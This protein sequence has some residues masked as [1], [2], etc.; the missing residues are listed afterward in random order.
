[1]SQAV[2]LTLMATGVAVPALPARATRSTP[3]DFGPVLISDRDIREQPRLRAVGPLFESRELETG[4]LFR[5]L[6]PLFSKVED[7][8]L[9][10]L[11]AHFLWPVGTYLRKGKRSYWRFLSVIGQNRDVEDPASPYRVWVLPVFFVGRDPAG[12]NYLAVFPIGGKINR[13]LG[14]DKVVFV[15]FPLYM[16]SCAGTTRSYD[17]LWPIISRTKGETLSHFRIFPFY[18]KAVRAGR[19]EKM[20]VLWPFWTSAKYFYEGSSGGGFVLFPLFGHVKLEDQESWMV[21]PPFFRWSR[22]KKQNVTYCP[23]PF[24][25]KSSGTIDKLYF[26]PVWGRKAKGNIRQN[27]LFWPVF[28]KEIRETPR[29]VSKSY[30]ARPFVYYQSRTDKEPAAAEPRTKYLKIW[31]LL[32]YEKKESGRRLRLLDLYPLKNNPGIE[33]NW[34]PLW[35][36]YSYEGNAREKEYELL[37]GLFRRRT[38][39]QQEVYTSLFPLVAWRATAD[40]SARE[41]SVLKGLVGYSRDGDRKRFRLLYFL[42][43]GDTDEDDAGESGADEAGAREE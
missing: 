14:R 40:G 12:E 4:E 42:K 5:A 25:Q 30:A 17:V 26:W 7:D 21:L 22:G 34:A 11:Q 20:F 41:W 1:M 43:F 23:W 35:T 31:P 28:S 3:A 33:R 37:W 19:S 15:L 39:P 27:F 36:L 2:L 32:C 16:Y 8:E 10:T 24:F 13:V 38:R 9:E 18:G 29:D 6:R